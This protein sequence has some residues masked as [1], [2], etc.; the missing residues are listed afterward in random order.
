MGK[1]INIDN[2][3]TLTDFCVIDGVQVHHAKSI[4]T[5]Y[6]LSKCLFDGLKTVSTAIYGEERLDLLLQETDFIRYS[7]TQGTNA[8]VERKG[9]R[10]GLILGRDDVLAH[11]G[12]DAPA[13]ALFQELVGERCGRLDTALQG[14]ELERHAVGLVNALSSAGANRLVISLAAPGFAQLEGRLK[15]LLMRRF[16]AHLLGAV[17]LLFAGELSHDQDYARRTWTALFNA[18]LHPQMERFLYSAEHRIKSFKTRNPLLVFRNDGGSA[19][20][21]KT[22]AIKTYSSGPR[23][24][25][26]GVCAIAARYGMQHAVSFD[27]GGTTTDIGRIE[28]GAIRSSQRGSVE[29]VPIAFPLCDIHSA[30][31]GGSSIIRVNGGQLRVGPDSVGAAPGP[32]CFGLGGTE[33]TITDAFLLKGVLDAETFFGGNLRLDRERAHKVVM[34]QVATPLGMDLPAAIA[35]MEDQWVGGI[36]T[37][38][39][40][41]APIGPDTVLVAFGGAGA[42]AATAIADDCGARRVL[43]PALAA[44]FSAYGITFSDLTHDYELPLQ[45]SEA[46]VLQEVFARLQDRARRDMFAEGVDFAQCSIATELVVVGPEAEQRLPYRP[47]TPLPQTAGDLR[48]ALHVARQLPRPPQPAPHSGQGCAAATTLRRRVLDRNGVWIDVPLYRLADLPAGATARGPALFE[49]PY[50]TGTLGPDWDMQVTASRDVMLT[51]I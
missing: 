20:V 44:V 21:A 13:G 22:T 12:A 14:E 23:G 2:G 36:A 43:I 39:R 48:L 42:M 16:P 34:T 3:G 24:G 5:P 33:A 31:I 11:S 30:G 9:P 49:D 19:R 15:R 18:F 6:D 8:L 7:T 41:F 29:G 25:M 26:E 1:L 10:L 37:A 46:A 17:P 32:A 35:A 27:V 28:N 4:T 40:R 45:T 50:F 47:G 38:L 51:R